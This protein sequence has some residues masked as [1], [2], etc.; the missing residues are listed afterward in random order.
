MRFFDFFL[1]AITTAFA[2]FWM[3]E[4]FLAGQIFWGFLYGAVLARNLRFAYKIT[5]FIRLV[6]GATKK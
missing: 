2:T 3:N 4:A 1:L 5:L 6:E